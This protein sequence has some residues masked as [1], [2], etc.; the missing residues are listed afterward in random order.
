MYRFVGR[1]AS[2][3]SG[4]SAEK[5]VASIS[6]M[7]NSIRERLERLAHGTLSSTEV[8]ILSTASAA[9]FACSIWYLRRMAPDR[10]AGTDTAPKEKNVKIFAS[11][12]SESYDP[13]TTDP[14]L[15][16]K[17]SEYK[18]YTTSRFTYSGLRIFYRRH[19][20]ADQLPN[21][22]PLPLLVCLHGLGGS[23]AQFH[24]LLTSLTNISNCLAIDLPGC[25]A[26]DFTETSWDAYK[27]DALVELLELIIEDYRDKAAGQGVVLIAHSMGC[28]LGAHLA[29]KAAPHTTDLHNHV[30]GLVAICPES[31]PPTEQQ[32]SFFRKLLWIPGP[33]FDL[34]RAWDRRG[35]PESASVRRFVGADADTEA[36]RLQH[37]YNNQ[38]RTSV[39]RRMAS[40]CLPV[41]ENGVPKGGLPGKEVWAGL[42]IPVYL[43]GG[44]LD[45]VTKPAEV[46]KIVEILKV[47]AAA[48]DS[49][50]EHQGIVDAAAPVDTTDAN[51]SVGKAQ[52]IT[53]ITE[54]DFTRDR[55]LNNTDES[56]EDPDPSTPSEP[57]SEVPPL[58]QHPKKVV[59]FIILPAPATHALL[60]TPSTA[61]VLAGLVSDFL[62]SHVSGR[63]SLGWQL[64]YLSLEGKWD[65]KNLEKWKK[66]APVSEPIAGVFRAMKTLR[67]LDETHTPS[68]FVKNWGHVI[69]DIVD[70]SHDSPVYDPRGLETGGVQYHK[71]P[72]VSKIPPTDVE[73]NVFIA[74]VDRLRE[75]QKKRAQEQNWDKDYVIGVHC[76]YGFNRTGYFIVCYII[77]RCGYSVKDAIDA[78]AKARPNGIRHSHFLDNLHL[79]SDPRRA[80]LDSVEADEEDA[81][82]RRAA[83]SP[84]SRRFREWVLFTWAFI[85]TVA[86][87]VLAVFF[88]HRQQ[89]SP[90]H[91][92]STSPSSKRNLIFMVSDGMGPTSLSMTRSFRQLVDGLPIDDT[93]VLDRHFWGT[94][95]T[96]SSSSLVTDSAAGATAFSCGRKSYNGAIAVDPDHQ[97]CGT[98]D[99]I[100]LQE[101]GE[102]VLGRSVDLMF[103]GGRCRF[104]PNS[105]EGSC[106]GDDVD[107]AALAQEKHGWTYADD[108]AGFEAMAGG[109][110]VS[111]PAL[112][113]FASGDVPFEIDRR[114]MGDVYPSLSEM[115]GTAIKA[116]ADATKD[117]DK[118]FFLMIEGSRI[119]HAGHFNDPAAQ[120]REVLEYDA[121]FQLVL[122]FLEESDTEGVLVATSDHETG[123]LA[124]A[125]QTPG[126]LPVYDWHPS[127]LAKADA[128][129]EYLAAL[130][131]EHASSISEE[132]SKDSSS[133]KDWINTNLVIQRLGVANAL[134][135]E[136]EALAANPGAA[137]PLFAGLVSRRARIGWST[138]G[139]SAVDVNVYSSGGKGTEKIRGNVENTDIGKFLRE[140]LSVDVDEITKEL[141][142]KMDMGSLPVG[143]MG[144][145]RVGEGMHVGL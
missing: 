85:A 48:S 87:I 97:P 43:I 13:K 105:T 69:K 64:Q 139:H 54:D 91:D 99:E 62:A 125:W 53:D 24:P 29:S 72:T 83:S 126:Q 133:L 78:F 104:L 112:G 82:L 145:E 93:L 35:G 80:S 27:T 38:S 50:P 144:G 122:D 92:D 28:S 51:A 94:S 15:L 141:R 100:A 55:R 5:L 68:V 95:R 59:K 88:Q 138:G 136:L 110:N 40:G 65:V 34:W 66:V 17:H 134:D 120:V 12:Q 49:E 11:P 45:N 20:Q 1:R 111:L 131:N 76:H 52:S 79:R 23:V 31:G 86:V 57:S 21:T 81:L 142:E 22:P 118:G 73:V 37:L 8:L 127:V 10:S 108:R 41:Y 89:T 75:E 116:L 3:R 135:E 16:K 90:S 30:M 140:Y 14:A 67:E 103:G 4:I 36:K 25:G 115:A 56:Q 26:S 132:V 71:L 129:A 98:N 58:P 137:V 63:L 47:G 113:L 121:T 74:T 18:S 7:S 33:L 106:R 102:G 84:S 46:G 6:L 77:E 128:S 101:V 9:V 19:T 60:Y 39:W 2:G 96:R 130:L 119:D 124:T 70:I 107:V 123:G 32:V 143:M 42:D 61:R 114:G 44:E 117:S 109:K